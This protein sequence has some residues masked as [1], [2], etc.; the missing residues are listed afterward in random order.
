MQGN[1]NLRPRRKVLTWQHANHG[2][3]LAVQTEG[4][5]HGLGPPAEVSLPEPI[6]EH[7]DPL[8]L[9]A[10]RPVRLVE[11]ASE[12]GRHPEHVQTAC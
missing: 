2:V 7:D 11:D 4:L 12:E 9:L 3:G 8:G 5:P 1:E 10:R 6:R